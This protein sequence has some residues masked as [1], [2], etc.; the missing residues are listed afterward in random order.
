[1]RRWWLVLLLSSFVG[2]PSPTDPATSL[3]GTA[4]SYF[5]GTDRPAYAGRPSGGIGKAA[6]GD[7]AEAASVD[8]DALDVHGDVARHAYRPLRPAQSSR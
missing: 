5:A 7:A 3:V 4:E 6:A 8:D 1:M 2:C